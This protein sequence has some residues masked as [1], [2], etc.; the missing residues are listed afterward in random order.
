MN[1]IR[2]NCPNCHDVSL[3]ASDVTVLTIGPSDDNQTLWY[4]FN[5]P[6][7]KQINMKTCSPKLFKALYQYGCEH[8][9]LS[10]PMIEILNLGEITSD[11]I[12]DFHFALNEWNGSV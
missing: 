4:R 7:C 3:T 10:S 9:I 11:E 1:L 12:I 6:L 2:G 5:C 8:L